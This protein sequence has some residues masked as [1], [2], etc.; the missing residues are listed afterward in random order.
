MV[1]PQWDLA[2]ETSG[3]NSDE[4]H[5]ALCDTHR[6]WCP[7]RWRSLVDGRRARGGWSGLPRQRGW[8]PREATALRWARAPLC[9][10][11][12][13]RIGGAK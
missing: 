8:A 10:V 2:A 9:A 1:G 11:A 12:Q 5:V 13:C 3:V 4:Y 6:H 7:M